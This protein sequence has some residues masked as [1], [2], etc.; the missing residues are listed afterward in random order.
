MS[1]AGNSTVAEI[2]VQ[3]PTTVRVFERFGIDYCCGGRKPLQ[4]VCNELQL[5]LDQVME[6]L[7]QAEGELAGQNIPDWQSASLARLM[8]HIV[9]KHHAFVRQELPRLDVMSEKVQ[10]RHGEAHPELAHVRSR[11]EELSQDLLSH[12]IKEEQ[13]LFPYIARLEHEAALGNPVGACAFGSVANPIRVMTAE[14][15]SAGTLVAEI[16]RLTSGYTPP[17]N[18]CPSYRA[19]FFALQEFE[20][21]LHEHVHLENNILFPR[22][23]RLEESQRSGNGA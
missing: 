14:H 7:Q 2:A 4:Q 23:L 20:R 1:I 17:E 21:D 10:T 18:A 8:Q 11:V 3:H 19:L 5:S 13:V 15:D 12:M 16:R 9:R 6:K 22:A